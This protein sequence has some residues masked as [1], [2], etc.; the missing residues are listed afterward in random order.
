M[1][2]ATYYLMGLS[3][4][5]FLAVKLGRLKYAFI[6]WDKKILELDKKEIKDIETKM[7]NINAYQKFQRIWHILIWIYSWNLNKKK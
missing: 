6:G 3:P 1:W 7:G 2:E 5:D 4:M